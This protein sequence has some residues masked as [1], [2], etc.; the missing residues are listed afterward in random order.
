MA[1]QDRS[2]QTSDASSQATSG[3]RPK[4]GAPNRVN[5]PAA[6]TPAAAAST[7]PAAP[8]K[9]ADR[10]AEM[11]QK[12]R[13]ERLTQ[14]E[15][16][17]KEWLYTRIGLGLVAV[18]ILGGIG[19]GAWTAYDNWQEEQDLEGVVDFDSL[20]SEHVPDGEAVPYVESPPVGGPHD[21][22]WQNCG[23]YDGQVRNENA[24]H[25][26]EHGTVWITYRPDLPQE[27]IDKLRSDFEGEAYVL[28]S[29]YPGLQAPVVAQTWGHQLV[30]DGVDDDRLATFVRVYIQGDDAP[31]RG[32]SCT[33]RVSTS[34]PV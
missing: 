3:A 13:D 7:V 2:G 33:G 12:R 30:L 21:N 15:R 16:R 14:Y 32:A 10:R 6:K 23:F 9:R 28:V 4:T 26:L 11:I 25:S 34:T 22:A 18:L 8:L 20:V 5:K 24:V 1:S 31:E 27:D 19:W 29:A 17:K